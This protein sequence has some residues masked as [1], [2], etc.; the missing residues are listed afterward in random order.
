MKTENIGLSNDSSLALKGFRQ[1]AEWEPH[2][3]CWTA[4]PSNAELWLENLSP[5]QEELIRLCRLIGES[6][7]LEILVTDERAKGTAQQL[8]AGINVRFHVLPFGDIWLRDTAPIFLTN[9]KGELAAASFVFNGWGGK[10]VLPHDD[11]VAER[12]SGIASELAKLEDSSLTHF[13]FPWVLEGGSVEVDGQGTCLTTRQCLLNPNRN[14]GMTQRQ[15]EDGLKAALGS[16]S[17]LWLGDGLIN[18]HTDGHVD[19]I[20]RFVAPGKVVCMQAREKDDPN[21]EVL[22]EIADALATFKT[23]RGERLEVLRIPSPGQAFDKQGNLMPASFVNSHWEFLC[24][25]RPSRTLYDE[26]GRRDCLL[27]PRPENSRR[28][29]S[30]HPERGRSLPL[31][32]PA[33]TQGGP[34]NVT[35]AALQCSFS[36]NLAE[37]VAR[38]TELTREAASKGAQIIL[39]S[40]LFEGPYFC[41]E[42]RDKF[43]DLARPLEGNPTIAHFRKLAHELGVAI[44]VSFSRRTPKVITIA[45]P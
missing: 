31:H 34:M 30:S 23:A 41:R 13:R 6:E 16:T 29:S 40:E 38:I 9:S 43:F 4:W 1:P 20:A 36:E 32:Y 19:T 24:S 3:A 8:L 11:R 37:N 7:R 45:S 10:Y 17:V 44:P 2:R 42:E 14:P 33:A 21:R 22:E 39:P 18:D 28:F 12:I 15:I 26:S 25:F 27:F 35:V 5:A